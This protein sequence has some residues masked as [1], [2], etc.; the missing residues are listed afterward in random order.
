[1]ATLAAYGSSWARFESE[2]Q[3]LAYATVTA[4]WDPSPICDLCCNLQQCWIL[5]HWVRPQ[6]EPASSQRQYQVLNPLSH[7]RNSSKFN[8]ECLF[9][10]PFLG[11]S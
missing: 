6:I 3:L 1:M 9:P 2:L 8:V 10:Y 4:T 5:N 7:N 11:M